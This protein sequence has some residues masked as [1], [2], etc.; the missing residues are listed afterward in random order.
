MRIS[1]KVLFFSII[2][3][4]LFLVIIAVWLFFRIGAP[5]HSIVEQEELN[6]WKFFLEVS[7]AIGAGFLLAALGFLIPH[8]LRETQH[9]IERIE[10]SRISYT[11]ATIAEQYLPTKMA[12]LTY[13]DAVALIESVHQKKHR[14][15]TYE[16]LYDHLNKK[17]INHTKWHNDLC[18]TFDALI[19][20]LEKEISSW[21]T[22]DY[23]K[24]LMIIRKVMPWKV[25]NPDSNIS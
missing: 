14:A 1:A 16:E 4:T 15:E 20:L 2:G 10:S 7:E 18:S 22:L 25:L 21:D 12:S 11:E 8:L 24:R 5:P 13:A 23:Q 19:G 17:N 9:K 3:I 6:H